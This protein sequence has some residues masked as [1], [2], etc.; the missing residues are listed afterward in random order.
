[1]PRFF[2]NQVPEELV[3][4]TGEDARHI[5]RSLRMKPGE[6]VILCDSLGTDYNGEIVS[7]SPQEVQIRVL[8][9]CRTC[10]LY[11]SKKQREKGEALYVL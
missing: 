5:A 1:M 3:W 8:S 11:T 9:F 6:N 2:I 4:I 7:V 10:L